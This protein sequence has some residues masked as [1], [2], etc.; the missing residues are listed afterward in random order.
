MIANVP[1]GC[2]VTGQKVGRAIGFPYWANEAKWKKNDQIVEVG[3]Y[4]DAANFA[5][6]IKCPALVALGLIDE[7]CPPAGVYSAFNQVKGPKEVVVMPLSDHQGKRHNAQA[8]FYARSEAWLRA[9][10]K[11]EAPPVK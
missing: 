10:A 3:R 1:A 11:G 7:T 2:D 6:R 8:A 4:F 5:Q 9:L